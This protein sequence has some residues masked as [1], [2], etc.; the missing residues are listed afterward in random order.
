MCTLYIA[1]RTGSFVIGIYRVSS[2][3]AELQFCAKI[4]LA[5]FLFQA[6]CFQIWFEYHNLKNVL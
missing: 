1:I 5:L 4:G 3:V 6:L 2:A